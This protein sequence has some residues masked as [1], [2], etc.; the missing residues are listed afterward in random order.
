MPAEVVMIINLQLS[1]IKGAS[2]VYEVR[3]LVCRI[4][5]VFS[6]PGLCKIGKEM[7]VYEVQYFSD[8]HRATECLSLLVCGN[9]DRRR[10]LPDWFVNEFTLTG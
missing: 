3:L 2:A 8:V 10:H 9:L 4:Y 5:I 1:K 6:D 7:A